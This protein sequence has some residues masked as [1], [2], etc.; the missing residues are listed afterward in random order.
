M[1]TKA[2]IEVQ[3]S[4]QMLHNDPEN[5]VHF[6]NA[7]FLSEE[8]FQMAKISCWHEVAGFSKGLKLLSVEC[9]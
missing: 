4:F 5:T 1:R 6:M 9:C 3:I 2:F 7:M 8:K